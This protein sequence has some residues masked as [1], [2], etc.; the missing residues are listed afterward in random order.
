[1]NPSPPGTIGIGGSPPTMPTLPI[2]TTVDA[3]MPVAPA[4]SQTDQ[5][6]IKQGAMDKMS[7]QLAQTP[8]TAITQSAMTV[9]TVSNQPTGPSSGMVRG[10]SGG[11]LLGGR[12]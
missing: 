1:M 4:N 10:G 8:N 11:A 6:Q 3:M 2:T 5:E 7:N 9:P 12:R